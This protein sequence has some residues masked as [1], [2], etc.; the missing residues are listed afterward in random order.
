MSILVKINKKKD[1]VTKAIASIAANLGKDSKKVAKIVLFNKKGEVLMLKRSSKSKKHPKE[2]DLPGGHIKKGE[3]LNQGLE[4]EV[5]EETGISI[6]GAKFYKK[7]KHKYFFYSKYKKNKIQLSDEHSE[8]AF[9]D[10][11]RLDPKEKFQ[12]IALEVLKRAIK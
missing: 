8:Y 3:N 11:K 9:F 5:R 6:S 4:R 1:K 7:D 12:K 10:S 2:W